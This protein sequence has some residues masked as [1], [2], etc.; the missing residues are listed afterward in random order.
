MK[1]ERSTAE[2]GEA[3]LPAAARYGA[4]IIAGP[5][6]VGKS[7]FAVMAAQ[8][9]GGEIVGADAFQIYEGLDILTAKPAAELRQA[10]P[11]HL[12]GEVPLEKD[13][14]VA[15][16]L[17]LAE[18]RMAEIRTRGKVPIVAGGT[19]LYIRAL[20][21]GLADL[22]PS[23][24]ALRAEL[25]AR[26]LAELQEQLAKLDPEAA[27]QVD[28]QN[29]RRVVRALEVCLLAGR[30][31]S[32]F[33]EEWTKPPREECGVVLR[34]DRAELYA[35]IDRRVEAMFAEGVVEEVER[36][37]DDLSR[38][39]RQALG[40]SVIRKLL[41]G[42]MTRQECIAAIQQATRRYAKRQMTWFRAERELRQTD[43]NEALPA[44]AA[45]L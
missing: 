36:A 2:A 39:A 35:R 44:L 10:V 1:H 7:D 12:I 20:L 28:L 26:P 14:D 45:M 42:E 33:R 21:R 11:H 15:Q 3:A 13:F 32:S 40:W 9:L 38:T 34:G 25:S 5:T 41:A 37:G 43:V 17:V 6:G 19:G 24:P 27:A 31:F 18:R 16:Y 22:P 23:D 8:R 29:P 4:L 30:P